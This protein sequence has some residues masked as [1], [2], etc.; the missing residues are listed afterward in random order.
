MPHVHAPGLV[1]QFDSQTLI[2]H[3]ATCSWKGD[4]DHA[5]HHGD[6]SPQHYYVCIDSNLKDALWV[7]LFAGP[8][9]GRKGIAAG[10]KSG[11]G[12]W[13]RSSSF[14]HAAQLCRIAHKTAQR[15]AEKAFDESSP[16]L[17]NRMAL[18]QLPRRD[19]FP[20][21]TTFNPMAG[22]VALR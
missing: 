8:A 3:G 2:A 10:A 9:P 22:N 4:G 21:D 7:P 12:R 11:S 15:A 19:E 13:T 6:L 16:K 18:T 5:Q 17:P 14:Y 20:A 1:L